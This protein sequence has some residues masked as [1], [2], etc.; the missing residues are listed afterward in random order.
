MCILVNL[1]A[2]CSQIMSV[3]KGG[4]VIICWQW[5][6]KWGGGEANA[7]IGWQRG[8]GWCKYW[9]WLTKGERVLATNDIKW[10]KI[11]KYTGFSPTHLHLFIGLV[12]NSVFFLQ[13][14]INHEL[15]VLEY[16]DKNYVG[17]REGVGKCWQ[18]WRRGE[19]GLGK[20]WLGL[21]KG[22]VW[23]G[24]ML[25][26]AD[27]EGRGGLDTPIFGLHNLWTAPK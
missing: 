24:E 20:C 6:T 22:G 2:S 8:Q 19:G 27:R 13:N 10:L 7:E 9:H 12:N 3:A 14:F 18:G 16:T 11:Y 4:G 15:N 21:T 17:K 5:L 26:M 1:P 23:A 25:P